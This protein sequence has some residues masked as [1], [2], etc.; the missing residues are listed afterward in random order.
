[1]D[2]ELYHGE[3][4]YTQYEFMHGSTSTVVSQTYAV[5]ACWLRFIGSASI[6][7]V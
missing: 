7:N 2:Y 4:C 1:M 5:S 3:D 6:T